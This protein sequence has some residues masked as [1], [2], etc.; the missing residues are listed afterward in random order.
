MTSASPVPT[1]EVVVQRTGPSFTGQTS[2]QMPF[3]LFPVN[4]AFLPMSELI[5]RR[6]AHCPTTSSTNGES[7][8][9]RELDCK[10]KYYAQ[11]M[12]CYDA[13]YHM[14]HDALHVQVR[15]VHKTYEHGY[16][17]R[18]LETVL[19]YAVSAHLYTMSEVLGPLVA[20]PGNVLK[21]EV[22]K[23]LGDHVHCGCVSYPPLQAYLKQP[24][25]YHMDEVF[26]NQACLTEVQQATKHL[27][28]L[29]PSHTLTASLPNLIENFDYARAKFYLVYSQIHCAQISDNVDVQKLIL[30]LER[31][32]GSHSWASRDSRLQ[33]MIDQT[34]ALSAKVLTQ[35]IET[36]QSQTS[37][38]VPVIKDLSAAPPAY[39]PSLSTAQLRS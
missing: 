30:S 10:I 25:K 35:K 14:I 36:V 26:Y 16:S 18:L 13:I 3:I 34:K 32:D 20:R 38:F 1:K 33:S 7:P 37:V 27:S 29:L 17:I 22:L 6:K 31:T 28:R 5:A 9:C 8:A 19:A 12:Q 21:Q 4:D 23:H 24:S 39:T 11:L 15:S 2:V